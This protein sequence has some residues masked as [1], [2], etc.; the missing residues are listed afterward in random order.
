MKNSNPSSFSDIPDIYNLHNF[1]ELIENINFRIIIH[2]KK[3][4]KM[5][6]DDIELNYSSNDVYNTFNKDKDDTDEYNKDKYDRNENINIDN[7]DMYDNTYID[8]GIYIDLDDIMYT[9]NIINK[10]KYLFL[11]YYKFIDAYFTTDIDSS[12]SIVISSRDIFC[13][14]IRN[15]SSFHKITLNEIILYIDLNEST[16]YETYI[17]I[18]L[19]QHITGISNS[20]SNASIYKINEYSFKDKQIIF[21]DTYYIPIFLRI[22]INTNQNNKNED[23]LLNNLIECN[24]IKNIILPLHLKNGIGEIYCELYPENKTNKLLSYR[25]Y[26]TKIILPNNEIIKYRDTCHKCIK[27]KL[28][29]NIFNEYD[30][31]CTHRLYNIK[32]NIKKYLGQEIIIKISDLVEEFDKLKQNLF[33]IMLYGVEKY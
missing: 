7:K 4:H 32:F 27:S 28:K 20:I 19:K 31:I 11:E 5:F 9:N 13:Q 29:I 16:T 6:L 21:F 2:G 26:F 25:L 18:N 10:K 8:Y 22:N 1:K 3:I 23:N 17:N 12:S 14:K 33:L 24:K 30:S 15:K